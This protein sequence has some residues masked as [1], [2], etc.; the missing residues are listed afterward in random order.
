MAPL[1]VSAQHEEA[2]HGDGL[3]TSA[4]A[5]KS[6]LKKM[7]AVVLNVVILFKSIKIYSSGYVF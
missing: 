2:P 4:V 7:I 6:T 5:A 3:H 1:R